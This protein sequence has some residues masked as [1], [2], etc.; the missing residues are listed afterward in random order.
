MYRSGIIFFICCLLSFP[1]TSAGR[2]QGPHVWRIKDLVGAPIDVIKLR[3][4]RERVIGTVETKQML[5]VYSAY[6]A[7]QKASELYAELFILSGDDPNAF[8]TRGKLREEDEDEQNIIGFT[9]GMLKMIGNDVDAA[10]AII[11]HELAHLKLN[12]IEERKEANKNSASTA[13][14]ASSTKYTRDNERESDYLGAIWAV[15]AGYDPAGAVRVHEKLY[16]VNKRHVG[17]S[18][19]HPSSIERLT[20]LKSLVRRLSK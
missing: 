7:M 18:G 19:S 3:D 10:A 11:G 20:I 1:A 2:N 12:H 8:A 15:E 16:K 9:F 13:F 4:E 17:F 14:S 5:L 6:V